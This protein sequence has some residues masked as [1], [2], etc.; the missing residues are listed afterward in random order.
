MVYQEVKK[1]LAISFG[2]MCLNIFGGLRVDQ[3]C[4]VRIFDNSM[5]TLRQLCPWLDEFISAGSMPQFALRLVDAPR[6][7]IN[8]TKEN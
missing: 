2:L 3:A 4:Q 6:F 7:S 8:A 1:R 5:G